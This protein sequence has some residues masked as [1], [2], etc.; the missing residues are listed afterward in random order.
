MKRFSR[1]R[2]AF[3]FAVSLASAAN[4]RSQQP[5]VQQPPVIRVGVDRVNVGVIVTDSAGHFVEGLR[6]EDFRVFDNAVEQPISGF[7]SNEDPAQVLLLVESGPA[8]LFVG[9]TNL[10]AADR[11]LASLA[12]GDRVALASYSR[13]PQ[14]LFDF[15]ADKSQ[16]RLALDGINFT[17][18]F[19]DLNLAGSLGTVVDGLASVPGKK[20]VVLLCS[21]V[22]TSS[23][24]DWKNALDKLTISDVRILAVSLSQ[25]LH[26]PAKLGKL[27][28]Q[29][30]EAQA[31]LKQGFAHADELLRQIAAATGG[32]AY[33]PKDTQDFD[34]AYT[35]IAELLRHEYSLA[36][37]PPSLD[38]RTHSIEVKVSG[39]GRRVD[40][41]QAYLAP[42][43]NPAN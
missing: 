24:A 14:L 36:F 2:L 9:K 4:L 12:T 16:A 17:N 31:F 30:K 11:L 27:S 5:P 33:Y 38:G 15:S 10:L 19:A 39:F 37:A 7:L 43:A 28:P 41:R 3:A 29:Q 42:S 25:N 20:S 32:R 26:K 6:P 1:A 22:D 23:D 8:V 40:H 13:T 21:G 34:R 18:G 35:E